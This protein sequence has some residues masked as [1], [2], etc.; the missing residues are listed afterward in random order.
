MEKDL[1]EV[2]QQIIQHMEAVTNIAVQEVD[3]NELL[4]DMRN[5]KKSLVK[6]I[7]KLSEK[8]NSLRVQAPAIETANTGS[9]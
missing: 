9:I 6:A 8:L 4:E 1:Q 2:E 5:Q 7:K 3:T